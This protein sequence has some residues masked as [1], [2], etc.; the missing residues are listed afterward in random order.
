VSKKKYTPTKENE[1]RR[2][3]Y[4]R[5]AKGQGEEFYTAVYRSDFH[6]Q[7]MVDWFTERASQLLQPERVETVHGQVS[8]VQAPVHPPTFAGYAAHIGVSA[9]C[10]WTW[11]KRYSAFEEAHHECKAI[12]EHVIVT[13]GAMG[14]YN[15]NV[16]TFML[17]NLH[18]WTDKLEQTHKGTVSLSFDAQDKDA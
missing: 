11:K 14:A 7:D 2:T 5:N 17:K 16:C 10:I 9:P 13:M 12:A 15:P 8:H 18:G 4:D 3:L 6:P 1:I